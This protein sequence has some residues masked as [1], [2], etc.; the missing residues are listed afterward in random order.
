MSLIFGKC[1]LAF[2]VAFKAKRAIFMAFWVF[3]WF[4]LN[5]QWKWSIFIQKIALRGIILQTVNANCRFYCNYLEGNFIFKV[6]VRAKFQFQSLVW[7]MAF[8]RAP[9]RLKMAFWKKSSGH[10]EN[11]KE[12]NNHNKEVVTWSVLHGGGWSKT[13]RITRGRDGA[14]LAPSSTM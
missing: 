9:C 1:R 3:F 11:W 13:H 4:L 2:F 10:T 8:W 7:T 14:H 12:N 6:I 5:F